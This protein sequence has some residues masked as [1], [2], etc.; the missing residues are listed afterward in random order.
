MILCCG[1]ALIDMVPRMGAYVP[2]V[3]GAVLNTAMALGRLGA[4]VGLL[5][6][7]SSDG[8]GQQIADALAES[9]VATDLAVRSDRVTTLAMVHLTD[10]QA[11]YSFYDRGSA[12]RDI[13]PADLPDTG[14]AGA[15]FCGG[16]S[17]CNP[18]GADS[19]ADLAIGWPRDK[20]VM[21]DP[22]IRPGFAEDDA[23]YRARLA[24][25]L[26]RADIVKLSD[27]DLDWL[28]LGAGTL[29]DKARAVQAQ[30]AAL[31]LITCGGDGAIGF[32][33]DGLRVQRP[34]VPAQVVDT[35]GAGDTF[36]AGCLWALHQR[37]ALT[38]DALRMLTK[39]D[40][41][42]IIDFAARVAA[43]TVSRAGANPPWAHEIEDMQ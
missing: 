20:V 19:F 14:A 13:R 6:G 1:E 17:L 31:V 42:G 18:P 22:N 16:I 12:T 40:L 36:N 21:V 43:V 37:G 32:G 39:D 5:T 25:V 27:A 34:A 3:G 35:I 24:R 10:G 26:G 11:R 38:P 33:A 2:H 41:A 29:D 7:L 4:P 23:A 15:L 9:G 8:F 28:M 30:G